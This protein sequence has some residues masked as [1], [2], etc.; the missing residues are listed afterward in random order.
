MIDTEQLI[1]T[2][3]GLG[4]ILG[5]ELVHDFP[6]PEIDP[7]VT[8]TKVGIQVLVGIFTLIS[9]FRNRRQNRK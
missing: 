7:I 2:A 4:G 1:D 6:T 5:V 3:K 9:L 8:G